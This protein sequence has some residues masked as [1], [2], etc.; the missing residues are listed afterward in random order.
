MWCY[1]KTRDII[2]KRNSFHPSLCHFLSGLSLCLSH[3]NLFSPCFNPAPPSPLSPLSL[4]LSIPCTYLLAHTHIASFHSHSAS[5]QFNMLPERCCAPQWKPSCRCIGRAP[6]PESQL[7]IWRTCVRRS[8]TLTN[9]S[10]YT[11][12]RN[13]TL[14]PCGGRP[15]VRGATCLREALRLE[16]M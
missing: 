14:A 13:T 16:E 3:S 6:Q 2:F 5:L 8:T 12:E 9:P 7:S 1:N 10:H 11:T 15:F 4:S